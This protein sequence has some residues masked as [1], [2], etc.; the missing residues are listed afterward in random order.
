M[1]QILLFSFCVLF[2]SVVF[3]QS[4]E[5]LHPDEIQTEILEEVVIIAEFPGKKEMMVICGFT[6][7]T[8]CYTT[9]SCSVKALPITKAA[10]NNALVVYPNPSPS[11]VFNIKVEQNKISQVDIYTASGQ[12]LKTLKCENSSE[13]WQLDLSPFSKGVYLVR[14][15][16]DGNELAV[17]RIIYH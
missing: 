7:A 8:E 9:F 10:D 13:N 17:K 5:A 1:R 15:L 3:S 6:T 16:M 11:G 14:F 12:F 4:E 2:S